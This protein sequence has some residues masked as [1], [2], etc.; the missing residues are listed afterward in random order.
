MFESAYFSLEQVGE[1][2]FAAIARSEE[3]GEMA[4]AGA[5]RPGAI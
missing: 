4:N 5:D 2:V 1:G 3:S